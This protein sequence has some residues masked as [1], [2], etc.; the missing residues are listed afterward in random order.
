[1]PTKGRLGLKEIRHANR[2]PCWK[3][4]ITARKLIISFTER[5]YVMTYLTFII[6]YI[7]VNKPCR[8]YMTSTF[9]S[10]KIL[11][12]HNL[13]V[14]KIFINWDVKLKKNKAFYGGIWI[15]IRFIMAAR[16]NKTYFIIPSNE[17]PLKYLYCTFRFNTFITYSQCS[18]KCLRGIR[19][20]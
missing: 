18:C 5:K 6:L 12:R 17:A 9:Y 16:G 3:K 11:T 14:Q 1:M 20:L 10:D 8:I 15:D 7:C 19:N 4:C 2:I 13:W